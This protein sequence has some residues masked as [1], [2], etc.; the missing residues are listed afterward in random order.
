M[1]TLDPHLYL[2]LHQI[3]HTLVNI[4][5]LNMLDLFFH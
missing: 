3:A 5:R 1:K 4:I 2:D